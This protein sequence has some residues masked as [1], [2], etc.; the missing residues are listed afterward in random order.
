MLPLLILQTHFTPLEI[1]PLAMQVAACPSAIYLT[2]PDFTPCL[3]DTGSSRGFNIIN[4]SAM[5][6]FVHLRF[7]PHS[8]KE[9]FPW[10]KFLGERLLGQSESVSC[11]LPIA[12]IPQEDWANFQ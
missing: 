10:D 1:S 3:L 12:I 8:P 6:V 9:L 2:V 11:F 4:K 7:L 5:N